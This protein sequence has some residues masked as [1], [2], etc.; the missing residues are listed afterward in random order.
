MKH[1]QIILVTVLL[2]VLEESLLRSWLHKGIS[3]MAPVGKQYPIIPASQCCNW[4]LLILHQYPMPY[5]Q[6]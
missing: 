2:P 1:P 6:F 3:F 4:I 5:R